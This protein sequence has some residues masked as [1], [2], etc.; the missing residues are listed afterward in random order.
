LP[1]QPVPGLTCAAAR[2]PW[3]ERT[4]AE[5]LD[6]GRASRADVLRLRRFDRAVRIRDGG[7]ADASTRHRVAHRHAALV[8]DR[9]GLPLSRDNRGRLVELRGARLGW[10]LGLGP[11][12]ER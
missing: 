1:R 9:L 4:A 5:P 7:A 6:D 10:L 12:R 3:P 8:A 11:G 2:W